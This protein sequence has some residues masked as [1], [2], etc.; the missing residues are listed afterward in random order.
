MAVSARRASQRDPSGAAALQETVDEACP[1]ADMR[2]QRNPV[3]LVAQDLADVSQAGHQPEAKMPLSRWTNDHDESPPNPGS[4]TPLKR[5]RC[6]NNKESRPCG[7]FALRSRKCGLPSSC[8]R[9][10]RFGAGSLVVVGGKCGFAHRE[11]PE[12]ETDGSFETGRTRHA[13]AVTGPPRASRMGIRQQLEAEKTKMNLLGCTPTLG[14]PS[15]GTIGHAASMKPNRRREREKNHTTARQ[16]VICWQSSRF[17]GVE[18]AD[19]D[20]ADVPGL[21]LGGFCAGR[22]TELRGDVGRRR[23]S[24]GNSRKP[25]SRSH[26]RRLAY[27]RV[28]LPVGKS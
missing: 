21:R 2:A 3:E 11:R 5:G 7:A 12:P 19:L 10:K 20:D 24:R 14:S 26:R 28:T 27:T 4:S 13:K 25:L 23:G 8:L 18:H 1:L 15:G 9:S 16:R 22:R 17:E 6:S